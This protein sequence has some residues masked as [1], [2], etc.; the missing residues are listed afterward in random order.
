M[1][2]DAILLI[3]VYSAVILIAG[4]VAYA[5]FVAWCADTAADP[6]E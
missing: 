1:I 4:I 6:E 5:I 3:T 2:R